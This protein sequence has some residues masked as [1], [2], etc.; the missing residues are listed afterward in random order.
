MVIST[1][2]SYRGRFAPSP[3]GGL[4]QGSLTTALASWLEARRHGGAWLIRMDDLDPPRQMAGADRM[5]I[6]QL[7]ELGLEPDERVYYQSERDDAYKAAI[8]RLLEQGDAFYCPL[9]RRQLRELGGI[10]PGPDVAVLPREDAAIRLAVPGAPAKF[11]DLFQGAQQA[12]L[13]QEGGAFTLQRRDGPFGYQLACA[14]DEAWLGITHVI[15]G[16]D[17]IGSTFRQRLVQQRLGLVSPEYGHLPV[18]VDERGDKLAKSSG[19]D[20][21]D[22]ARPAATLARA[23]EMLGQQP[24]TSLARARSGEVLEWARHHWQPGRLQGVTER[25]AG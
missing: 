8:E 25:Q 18:L 11:H 15:R 7:S 5:L 1:E 16:A 19:A 3:T 6:H 17:L 21:V 14:V 23:L 24:P 20:V 13:Q 10:H 12:D 2:T 9:S 22:T 4:H